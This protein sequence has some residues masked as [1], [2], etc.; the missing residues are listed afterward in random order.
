[1]FKT[2]IA[3]VDGRVGGRDAAALGARLAAASGGRLILAHVYPFEPIHSRASNAEYDRVM[4]DEAQTLLETEREAAGVSGELTA[5]GDLSPARGLHRLAEDES[6]DLIV[7]G[8]CHRG[9]LGR[10]FA[11]DD[12]RST[13]QGAPCAVAVAMQTSAERTGPFASIGVGFDGSPES[14]RALDAAAALVRADGGEVRLLSVVVEPRPMSAT[15]AYVYDWEASMKERRRYAQGKLDRALEAL[16]VPARGEVLTGT[17]ALALEQLSRDVDLLVV[18]A[19]G[20]G[21]VRRVILG[22]TSDHVIRHAHC[23][24]LIPPRGEGAETPEPEAVEK[25]MV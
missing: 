20:F 22:S 1:M 5:V 16:D 7:V 11:G 12:A 21:P 3:G 23:P 18:G 6:A 24:V 14:R 4:R 19:R 25:M 13:M 17:P 2:I 10:V 15:Y 8:S 9:T